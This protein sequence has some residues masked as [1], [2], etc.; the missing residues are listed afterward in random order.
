MSAIGEP[1]PER[2]GGRQP[3]VPLL[4]LY[5]W[6]QLAM[7]RPWRYAAT[8][9][10]ATGATS[11]VLRVLLNDLSLARNAGLAM[12]TGVGFAVFACLYAARITRSFPRQWPWLAVK[13]GHSEA[14][15]CGR[16]AVPAAGPPGCRLPRRPLSGALVVPAT[17][18][19]VRW[20]REP[21][22]RAGVRE[23]APR[24]GC[25]R[26]RRHRHPAR[27]CHSSAEVALIVEVQMWSSRAE[28]VEGHHWALHR[29]TGR[30]LPCRAVCECGWTSTAG[31]HTTVLLQLKGHLEESIGNGAQLVRGRNQ[32]ATEPPNTHSG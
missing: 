9:V 14:Q 32:P 7:Q 22:V 1:G 5:R 16:L 17:G 28:G 26:C 2:H 18:E 23:A 6:A 21:T 3:D 11:F 27:W 25:G 12:L 20:A 19:D 8:W 15:L 13:A 10:I 29:T 31:Q 30:S 4:L 24:A